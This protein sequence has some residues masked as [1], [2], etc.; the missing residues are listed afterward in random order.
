MDAPG[1]APTLNQLQIRSIVC[2]R[3]EQTMVLGSTAIHG[4][5]L[6]TMRGSLCLCFLHTKNMREPSCRSLATVEGLESHGHELK[7]IMIRCD[8]RN[9]PHDS[10]AAMLRTC[11]L[12]KPHHL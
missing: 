6:N 3:S 2:G 10:W 5:Q 8:A 11:C 4:T 7:L 1:P 12:L 9:M